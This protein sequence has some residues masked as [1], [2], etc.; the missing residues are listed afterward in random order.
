MEELYRWDS[1][2]R[3]SSVREGCTRDRW[4]WGWSR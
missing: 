4:W 2:P 1:V 3:P